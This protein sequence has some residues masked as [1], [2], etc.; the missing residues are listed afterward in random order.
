MTKTSGLF[1]KSFALK[2]LKLILILA[3]LA[4]YAASVQLWVLSRKQGIAI[5]PHQL[6]WINLSARFYSFFSPMST[7][8]VAAALANWLFNLRREGLPL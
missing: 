8:R 6:F 7:G 3:L 2:S 4:V 5:L 1:T